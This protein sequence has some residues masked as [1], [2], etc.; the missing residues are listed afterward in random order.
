MHSISLPICLRYAF[1]EMVCRCLLMPA[2]MLLLT[3][4]L[5][6][7]S[8][9]Y[10][11][12]ILHG[13]GS[14]SGSGSS[15]CGN[16]SSSSRGTNSSNRTVCRRRLGNGFHRHRHRRLFRLFLFIITLIAAPM[17]TPFYGYL[18]IVPDA[19]MVVHRSVAVLE[20]HGFI[21]S[22]Q[23]PQIAHRRFSCWLGTHQ[24]TA[25]QYVRP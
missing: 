14:S 19:I 21:S 9:L 7:L 6:C 12:R 24:I 17:E 1:Y 13:R 25:D 15:G 18:S 3:F 11:H 20:K 2:H 23:F 10:T 16:S 8:W 5:G 22:G 4:S